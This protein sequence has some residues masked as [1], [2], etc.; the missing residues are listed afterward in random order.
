VRQRGLEALLQPGSFALYDSTQPSSL[1]FQRLFHQLVVQ[2]HIETMTNHLINPEK[3]TAI[4]IPGNAGLGVVL[5]N[6]MI[7]LA[8]EYDN[9]M[10]APDDLSDHLMHMITMTFNSSRQAMD[11]HPIVRELLKRRVLRYIDKNLHNSELCNGRIA[12]AQHISIRYLYKLF[13]DEAETI[14]A[15]ILRK[16][17]ERAR[18]LLGDPTNAGCSIEQIA[19]RTGFT[20]SSHFSRAFK[21]HY[22]VSPRDFR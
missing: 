16:R 2:I 18:Q 17:L 7:L 11:N 9:V 19:Y 4:A 3:H 5:V 20:Y 10:Q 6:F 21:K 8:R 22:G 13:Q 15:L 12:Q 1:T 14:H